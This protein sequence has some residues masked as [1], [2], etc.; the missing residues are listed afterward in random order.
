[1]EILRYDNA[2]R[3]KL[4]IMYTSQWISILLIIIGIIILIAGKNRKKM[5]GM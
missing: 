5:K 3:G 4:G 2:E 1:M